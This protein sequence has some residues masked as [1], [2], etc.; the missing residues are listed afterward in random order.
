ME[1]NYEG[2]KTADQLNIKKK[3]V[4]ISNYIYFKRRG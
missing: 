1:N 4:I 3:G 2:K